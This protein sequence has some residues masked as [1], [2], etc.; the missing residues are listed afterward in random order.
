MYW[1]LL[2]P[3]KYLFHTFGCMLLSLIRGLLIDVQEAFKYERSICGIAEGERIIYN[4]KSCRVAL[5]S[6]IRIDRS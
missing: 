4:V 5:A 6:F 1:D 2:I 3:A